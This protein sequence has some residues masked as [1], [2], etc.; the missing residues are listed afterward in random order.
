MSTHVH[1]Q[2]CVSCERFPTCLAHVRSDSQVYAAML[3]QVVFLDEALAT[4]V[5]DKRLD[6]QVALLM[7]HVR[8]LRSQT[9]AAHFT[10]VL[11]SC[12][13]SF[14]RVERTCVCK[15]LAANITRVLQSSFAPVLDHLLEAAAARHTSRLFSFTRCLRAITGR[16]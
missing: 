9:L 5:T 1:C 16:Y 7:S 12:V 6:C 8:V 3:H 2:V 14:V 4:I 10:R 11:H 15:E 13:Q